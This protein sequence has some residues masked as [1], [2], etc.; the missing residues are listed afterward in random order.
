[1]SKTDKTRPYT[2]RATEEPMRTCIPLHDHTDGVCDLPEV[3]TDISRGWGTRSCFWIESADFLYGHGNPCG[4]RA[5]TGY[6]WRLAER[7]T[8]RH[9]VAQACREAVATVRYL[10]EEDLADYDFYVEA[11]PQW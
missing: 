11:R 4:C 10:D 6:Y 8:R 3:P 7:R 9:A 1:M 5:C 2:L